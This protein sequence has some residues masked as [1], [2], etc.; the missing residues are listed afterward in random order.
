MPEVRRNR[1]MGAET[2][3]I[4]VLG[5]LAILAAIIGVAL[6][7]HSF[8]ADDKPASGEKPPQ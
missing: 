3:K 1:S 5:M 7:I 2:M 8:R 4:T 6:L